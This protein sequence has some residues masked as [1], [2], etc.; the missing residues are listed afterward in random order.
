MAKY[1]EISCSHIESVELSL[2]IAWRQYQLL[3]MGQNR[4]SQFY[5][6]TTSKYSFTTILVHLNANVAETVHIP[7]KLNVI[8]DGLS[9]LLS[10]CHLRVVKRGAAMHVGNDK[11]Y[12]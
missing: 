7:G 5:I 6:S 10:S 12:S 11:S 3:S 8:F 9:M 2:P 1:D 4:Q